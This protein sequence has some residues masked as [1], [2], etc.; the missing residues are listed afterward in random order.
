MTKKIIVAAASVGLAGMFAL[1]AFAQTT[2]S[3]KT[4]SAPVDTSAKITCVGTAVNTREQA[5]DTAITA[6]SQSVNSA[7]SARAKTL[8]Q[9]YAQT[10]SVAVKSA[11]KAAWSDFAKAIKSARKTWISDRNTAWSQYKKTAAA[12][13]APVGTGDGANSSLDAIGQ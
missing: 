5:I 10:T 11:V 12:C 13:K 2:T 4:A 7:Y 9:A 1:A 3:G 8:Q 6:Y